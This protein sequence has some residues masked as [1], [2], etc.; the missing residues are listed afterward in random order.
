MN[1]IKLEYPISKKDLHKG[2]TAGINSFII[3]LLSFDLCNVEA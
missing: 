1:S 2:F 3:I